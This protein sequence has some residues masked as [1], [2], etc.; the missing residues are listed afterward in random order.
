MKLAPSILDADFSKLQQELDSLAACD[1]IH[2]DI[3]DGLYVPNTSFWAEDVDGYVFPVPHEVHLMTENPR[4][5]FDSFIA[6][7]TTGIAF[8][9]EAVSGESE[10]LDLLA[11]LRDR[12]VRANIALDG[13]TNHSEL[14]DR[15]LENADQVL[16]MTIK[17]GKGG[18]TLLP[19]CLDK[20]RFLRER[21]YDKEI[22]I[23]GGVNGDTAEASVA[24]GIDIAVVGSYL[25]K[26]NLQTRKERI[27]LL[28]RV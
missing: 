16:V 24:A 6:L 21:G 11:E 7:G 28:H 3:M 1:R 8:H 23:D 12:G 19:E 10:A 9:I 25:M 14:T 15:I 2:L 4:Q 17:A 27:E 20:V 18:Q 26:A 13:Y 22:E 5:Y